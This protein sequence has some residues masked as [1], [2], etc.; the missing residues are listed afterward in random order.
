MN[1]KLMTAL[2]APALLALMTFGTLASA[3][4]VTYD[5]GVD[6]ATSSSPLYVGDSSQ[7]IY[8]PLSAVG[9]TVPGDLTIAANNLPDGVS[10]TLT[11]ARQDGD[12]LALS[13][14]TQTSKTAQEVNAV[15]ATANVSL[16]SGGQTLTIF[17]VPVQTAKATMPDRFQS[18]LFDN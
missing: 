18:A 2:T 9:G 1:K 17:Q 15:D 4:T 5:V 7:T 3:S 6:S 13:V 10:I 11:S 12:S 16:I 8:I 14:S